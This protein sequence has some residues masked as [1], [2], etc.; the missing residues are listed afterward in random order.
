VNRGLPTYKLRAIPIQQPA[1]HEGSVRTWKE[2]AVGYLKK[3]FQHVLRETEENYVN[4]L[5]AQPVN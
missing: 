4:L 5:S 2:V 1:W 3:L